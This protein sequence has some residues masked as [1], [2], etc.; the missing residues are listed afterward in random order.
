MPHHSFTPMLIITPINVTMTRDVMTPATMHQV[1]TPCQ[2]SRA[3]SQARPLCGPQGPVKEIGEQMG[4]CNSWQGAGLSLE[5]SA[6]GKELEG[7]SRRQ[8]H[9]AEK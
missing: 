2:A 3:Q 9:S 8:R 7:A 1:P 4:H 5:Q 6:V